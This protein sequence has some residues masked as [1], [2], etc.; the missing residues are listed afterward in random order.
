MKTA[1]QSR[2]ARLN[3]L[4]EY[5]DRKLRTPLEEAEDAREWREL[6]QQRNRAEH[7]LEREMETDE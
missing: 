5:A 7:R 4:D 1:R 2:K 6:E 3:A